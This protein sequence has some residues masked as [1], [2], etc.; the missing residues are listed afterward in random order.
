FS[1]HLIRVLLFVLV[2]VVVATFIKLPYYVT[3]P[4]MA[5]E[6]EPIIDVDN[7][8]ES[9]GDFLLTTV[10]MG[11][12]NVFTYAWA[13]LNKYHVIYPINHIRDKD[14]SD[15]EYTNRQ[16]FYMEDSQEAAITV[17]YTN[18][19]KEVRVENHGI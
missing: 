13:K 18:A 2:I 17:A 19:N 8:Y 14:E 16:L 1:K 4:G 7:G 15:E 11:R 12:A 5:K 6:L 10:R 9:E 3:T